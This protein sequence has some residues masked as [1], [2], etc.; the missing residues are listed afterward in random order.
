[1]IV[2][3]ILEHQY[4]CLRPHKPFYNR[5]PKIADDY[6]VHLLDRLQVLEL[7]VNKGV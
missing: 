7:L 3:Y 1:M 6:A 5:P 4:S 2:A